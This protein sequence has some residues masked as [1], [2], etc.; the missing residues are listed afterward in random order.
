MFQVKA[1]FWSS[2]IRP[3]LIFCIS[4][5]ATYVTICNHRYSFIHQGGQNHFYVLLVLLMNKTKCPRPGR[6]LEV[7]SACALR[8][9]S[10]C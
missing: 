8:F 10:F 3:G 1:V 4:A 6:G 9:F 2:G 7:F 5:R